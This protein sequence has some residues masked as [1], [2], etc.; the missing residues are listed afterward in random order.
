MAAGAA[1]RAYDILFHLADLVED[2]IHDVTLVAAVVINRHAGSPSGF[3]GCVKVSLS[4]MMRVFPERVNG[5]P[6]KCPHFPSKG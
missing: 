2:V 6:R 4:G 5:V 1:G 3:L